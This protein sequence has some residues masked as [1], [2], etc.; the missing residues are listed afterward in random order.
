LEIYTEIG[1][2]EEI[3]TFNKSCRKKKRRRIVVAWQGGNSFN[4]NFKRELPLVSRLFL[5]G[6]IEP[7]RRGNR[8]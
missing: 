3:A 6:E 8:H 7:Y 5:Q 2:F 1:I 4:R